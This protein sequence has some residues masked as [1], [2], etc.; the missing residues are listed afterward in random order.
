MRLP[1]RFALFLAA[2]AFAAA[3][4]RPDVAHAGRFV[5]LQLLQAR[6]CYAEVTTH[7]D[8]CAAIVHV[9][10]KR[11]EL[12]HMAERTM[13]RLYSQPMRRATGPRRWVHLLRPEGR[14]PRGWPRRYSW[15]RTQARFR[16]VYEHVGR[17]MRGEV[18]DPCPEAL[19]YG[20]PQW[21][22]GDAPRGFERDPACDLEG[23]QQRFFR[24]S[25]RPGP[26]RARPRQRPRV[27]RELTPAPAAP[28]VLG[29]S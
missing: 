15:P 26:R 21:L 18:P 29:A 17:V 28:P 13:V 5:P 4:T 24:R 7:L 22:D 23:T 27:P 9:H 8:A 14:A 3:T 11:A 12:R 10:K 2:C 6:S 19:H 16:A 20:G 1:T 25:A